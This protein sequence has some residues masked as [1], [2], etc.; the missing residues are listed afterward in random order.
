MLIWLYRILT[1]AL[2]PV[3]FLRLLILSRHEP[4]YCHYLSERLGWLSTFPPKRPS[5]WLHAVSVGEI[6]SALSLLRSLQHRY[7]NHNIVVT[8]TTPTG[9]A[10]IKRANID[11]IYCFYLP[12]D[13]RSAIMRFI[14][15]IKPDLAIFIEAEIWP[16]L[17]MT[18]NQNKI[19]CLL[20]NARLSMRS[21]QRFKQFRKSAQMILTTFDHISAQSTLDRSRF[22]ELGVPPAR[23]SVSPNLKY[24]L[25]VPET[26]P[27]QVVTLERL[28]GRRPIWIAASTH[29]G[30]DEIMLS[31]QRQLIK[32]LPKTLLILA[33][34]HPKRCHDLEQLCQNAQLTHC[35]MSAVNASLNA[36]VVILDSLGIMMALYRICDI[37][38]VCGSFVDQIGGHNLLEPSA[39]AKPIIT[40][41]HCFN[42]EDVVELLRSHNA[43]IQIDGTKLSQ[44]LIDLFQ[45]QRQRNALAMAAQHVYH[46]NQG[47][48]QAVMTL[49]RTI[50]DSLV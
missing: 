29:P 30:E 26:L 39:L 44:T 23:V 37:A 35:R 4:G 45:S 8:T 28:H 3:F 7:P 9:R 43:L 33:P 47:G 2:T 49:V 46:Q 18:L 40:G 12:Y 31:A 16:V 22:I 24:H 14:R 13:L 21:L 32:T 38:C 10:T 42:C 50:L 25:V 48:L 15:M 34:R 19:P 17:L 11:S 36:N 5:I 6:N 27:E 1:I 41:P 20:V